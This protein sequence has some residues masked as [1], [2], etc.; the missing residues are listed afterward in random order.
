VNVDDLIGEGLNEEGREETHVSGETDEV[1]IVV[2]EGLEAG[3]VVDFA[4]LAARDVESGGEIEFAGGGEAGCVGDVGDD[5]GDLG[6]GELTGGDG[7]VDG[8]EV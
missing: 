3:S 2:E 4:G 8:E 7:C 1:Y 6:V 5:D